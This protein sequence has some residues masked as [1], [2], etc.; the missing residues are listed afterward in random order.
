MSSPSTSTQPSD[1]PAGGASLDRCVRYDA[2]AGAL[3]MAGRRRPL[4]AEASNERVLREYVDL[5][6]ECRGRPLGRL[7][8][9]RD[10]DVD[11]LALALDLDADRLIAEIEAVLAQTPD[12]ARVLVDRLRTRRLQLAGA[13]VAAGVVVGGLVVAR[14]PGGGAAPTTTPTT[15][16]APSGADGSSG[17]GP[18]VPG[19]VETV[20]GVDLIPAVTVVNEEL[21][22]DLDDDREPSATVVVGEVTLL[23]QAPTSEA[24]PGP[25]GP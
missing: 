1:T 2:E 17:G 13:V 24:E 7:S 8:Q 12:E 11:A 5:V 10:E 14:S 9:V 3:L 22:G 23:E 20:P 21:D 4:G 16:V 25:A 6:A 18:T 19:V 15:V